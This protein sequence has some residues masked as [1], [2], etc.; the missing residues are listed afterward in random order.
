MSRKP[1]RI[2]IEP[3]RV[4]TVRLKFLN[5]HGALN[6]GSSEIAVYATRPS[7][8]QLDLFPL[9]GQKLQERIA[10]M[11]KERADMSRVA[12]SL[13]GKV[14][15]LAGTRPF[16]ELDWQAPMIRPPTATTPI[17][18]RRYMEVEDHTHRCYIEKDTPGPA[19]M[20]NRL[21]ILD[22]AKPDLEPQ[23]LVDAGEGWV[24]CAMS[25]T[26]DGKTLYFSMAPAG[27][28]FFH[29]YRVSTSGGEPEQLTWGTFHDVDPDVLPDG[30]IV[31]C[32][33]RFGSR[34]E[35][36]S[37]LVSTLFTMTSEGEDIRA[38]TYHVV[39]DREPR[40]TAQGKIVFVRQDNFFMNAKIETEIHQINLDGTGGF[41]LLGQD[42]TGSGYDR[43]TMHEVF[44]DAVGV[45]SPTRL[46]F[47]REG[48]AL[49]NPTPLPDG[50]VAALCA[51]TNKW[52]P[53]HPFKKHGIGVVVSSSGASAIDGLPVSTS[54][55]LHDIAAL[56]DGRLLCSTLD[57]GSLGVMDLE[58]GVVS[59]F[60]MSDEEEIQA[61]LYVGPRRK[62]VA[63]TTSGVKARDTGRST[64]YLFCQDVLQTKQI[65]ADLRRI[66]AVRVIEGRPL[67]T[68]MLSSVRYHG[69]VNHIGTEAVELGVAPLC[70]DGSFYIEAP[71]DRAL[72]LQAI[73]AEGRAVINELSWI[74]IRPG[75]RRACVGCHAGPT[76]SPRATLGDA[77]ALRPLRLAGDGSPFRFKANALVHGGVTGNSLDRIR[78]TKSINLYPDPR[79]LS[80]VGSPPLPPGRAATREAL[81]C[82]LREGPA[83]ER[84]SAA[85]HLG[86][87][88]DRL[89]VPDLVAALQDPQA[90]VRMN[91]A[92]ALAACGNRQALNALVEGILDTKT[93]VALANDM[94]VSHLTGHNEEL[95]GIRRADFQVCADRWRQWL[96][97]HDW[98][99][100]EQQQ[101][102]QL[103]SQDPQL[104]ILAV[105][106]LGHMGGPAAQE[107]LRSHIQRCLDPEDT[108]D[109]HS[110][111]D[112]MRG[113]G[114]LGDSKAIPL[115]ESILE[116]HLPLPRQ[117][118]D[119]KR[120]PNLE[121]SA[122]LAEAA[123]E[124]LGWIGNAEAE[125]VL[126]G[127]CKNL[128]PFW[129]YT[130]ALG[131]QGGGWGDYLSCSPVHFR[132]L[133]AFDAMGSTLPES[134][135]FALVLSLH[136][137][138]DQPLL[139]ESD[140]YETMLAR[141][142]QRSGCLDTILDSCFAMIEVEQ[143]PINGDF[144]KALLEQVTAQ[145]Y[146]QMAGTSVDFTVP[147]RVAQI[148]SVLGIRPCDAPRYQRA[149]AMYRERYLAIR[150]D[151]RGL[152]TGACVWICYYS[153]ETLGRLECEDAYETFL[154]ALSA[155]PP[156]A[157]DGLEDPTMPLTHLATTP[158][159]RVAAAFGLGQ[160]GRHEA[161]PA[162][163]EAVNNFDNALEVRHMAARALVKLCDSRDLGVLHETADAYP[164]VHTRRVLLTACE[165]A[166][167]RTG[168]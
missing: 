146:P 139:Q 96:A 159:Y 154:H 77:M 113:L 119:L 85:Q 20:G 94:A 44:P 81:C 37:Y 95:E 18:V 145:R 40:V 141:V 68:R 98:Q 25:A 99:W 32:S 111:V 151:Y 28:S 53:N 41:V 126:L 52:S 128:R 63:A 122:K 80:D 84:M 103:T 101:I 149:F 157:V 156:E 6:A 57:R 75:E 143:R 153:L 89:A 86:V 67:T 36:H 132:F 115:L 102:E 27:D 162:L 71:A 124:S 140:T 62:P 7:K 47:K 19:N 114:H 39:N 127:Q 49:G 107:A 46:N 152:E 29:I 144:K 26:H 69:G 125:A 130:V 13:P 110:L 108:T 92:L 51:P 158:H 166:S 123:A 48:N 134:D 165:E 106:T 167:K 56:P 11:E 109:L 10:L 58:T 43:Y 91:A 76:R 155:D 117:Q 163:L 78:E 17:Q 133:E 64:G 21:Y 79:P 147:Q 120:L 100:I 160:T 60:Y 135:V 14:V 50:R 90:E 112:A 70:P 87:L 129:H 59:T 164:E 61:P 24:G 118:S 82:R 35:Y 3:Q 105:Q 54:Q 42:V 121:R 131:D 12:S 2:A 161:V 1:Q 104:V 93:Q 31:F 22:P 66:K 83:A 73:D 33:T 116:A 38:I 34:E 72:A 55:P 74:Y 168:Q 150:E 9:A 16:N 8:A 142:V 5:S 97:R 4:Q 65:Q 23:L 137:S 30:G 138:F 15:F 88:R 45:L 148:L 136:M